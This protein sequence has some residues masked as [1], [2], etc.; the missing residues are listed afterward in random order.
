MLVEHFGHQSALLGV[1]MR[2]GMVDSMDCHLAGV[3]A[4]IAHRFGERRLEASMKV[5]LDNIGLWLLRRRDEMIDDVCYQAL[6]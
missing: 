2:R 4:V 6:N 3:A 1:A 5:D